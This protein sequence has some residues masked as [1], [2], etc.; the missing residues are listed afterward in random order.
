[1]ARPEIREWPFL[2]FQKDVANNTDLYRLV[3]R[4]LRTW[5]GL[6]LFCTQ[7]GWI[8][9]DTLCFEIEQVNGKEVIV[10]VSFEEILMEG[11]GCVAGREPCFGRLRLRL[12]QEGAVSSAE[13]F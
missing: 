12:N 13:P 3:D 2:N 11:S 8:D 9:N 5:P 7:N 4:F 1:M 6:N 10:T